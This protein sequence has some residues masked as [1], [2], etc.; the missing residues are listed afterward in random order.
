MAD[1]EITKDERLRQE[2]QRQRDRELIAGETDALVEELK[3]K[4]KQEGKQVK[5]TGKFISRLKGKPKTSNYNQFRQAVGK[6]F[7]QR[8]YVRKKHLGNLR[9]TKP[10]RR[11][12]ALPAG[13]Y[14][15]NITNVYEK[16]LAMLQN[17]LN[18]T[19]QFRRDREIPVDWHARRNQLINLELERQKIWARQ[20]NLMKTRLVADPSA[21]LKPARMW[22]GAEP[23]LSLW[24]PFGNN[25]TL[26]GKDFHDR[27]KRAGKQFRGGK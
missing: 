14:S 2:L 4:Y 8:N 23:S 26:D 11:F 18:K 19:Y 5:K 24:T 1:E 12:V 15:Q 21:D 17:R 6:L 27:M 16:R 20:H 3:Q 22:E 25:F 7:P 10:R 13:Q 9:F